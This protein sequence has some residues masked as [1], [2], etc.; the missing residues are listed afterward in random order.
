MK[1]DPTDV[2]VVLETLHICS[3][4]APLIKVH[5]EVKWRSRPTVMVIFRGS[6]F[7]GRWET[8][9]HGDLRKL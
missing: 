2:V 3:Q 7:V 9:V 4:V 5:H 6:F 8:Q 1:V